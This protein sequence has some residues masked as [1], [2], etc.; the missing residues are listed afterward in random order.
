MYG[1]S[2][3]L[4]ET[5]QYTTTN[6]CANVVLGSTPLYDQSTGQVTSSSLYENSAD[7]L[8]LEFSAFTKSIEYC[9]IVYTVHLLDQDGNEV[10]WNRESNPAEFTYPYADISNTEFSDIDPSDEY[11]TISRPEGENPGYVTISNTAYYQKFVGFYTLELRG[12]H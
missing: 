11:L 12:Y 2:S 3:S 5:L 4:T 1:D 6:S 8:V 9:T 10:T 7:P